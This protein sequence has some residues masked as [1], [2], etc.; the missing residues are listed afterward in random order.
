MVITPQLK[1]LPFILKNGVKHFELIAEPVI[2]EILP[3]IY[4]NAWGYNGSSPGPTILVYP[5][6][7][8]CIRVYNRLPQPTSVH[9]HG[10][11][12]PNVMD[13]VP[14]IES[15]PKIMPN[16]YFDYHFKITNP[17]GTHMYHAHYY[18]VFQD[19]MG[20]EGA[21][22]ILDP[23]EEPMKKD[24]FLMLGAF[25]LMNMPKGTLKKGTYTINPF[26]M[27]QNFF[28]MNG[29]CFPNTMPLPVQCE[30]RVRVRFGNVSM[31]NHPIHF[32]GH[33]FYITAYDGNAIRKE[34]QLLRNTVL[35]SSGIT[36]DI[37]FN[38]DNPGR[39][40]LHCHLPHHISNNLTLP[41]GGMTTAVVYQ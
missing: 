36:V 29:K 40:P 1:N 41:L 32:H 37:E 16:C 34:N 9:W 24:Y 19:M 22:I 18:T 23:K 12:V 8:V 13:G 35:V 30:D 17:P 26:S 4:M 27:D 25:H 39:W 6:D 21:L 20:L 15:S 2:T 3:G 38:A 11:D 5:D 7:E 33:Q 14:D 10:L 31:G 28:T